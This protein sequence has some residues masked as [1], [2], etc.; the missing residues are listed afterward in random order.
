MK[1]KAEGKDRWKAKHDKAPKAAREW[2]TSTG[3]EGRGRMDRE[4]YPKDMEGGARGRGRGGG[5]ATGMNDD[6]AQKDG[7]T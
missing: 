3:N 5:G 4:P 7:R 6:K 2:E 1:R